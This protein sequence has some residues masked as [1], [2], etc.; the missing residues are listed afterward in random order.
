MFSEM[1]FLHVI[2]AGLAA[3]VVGFVWYLPPVLGK[4]WAGYVNGS[5]SGRF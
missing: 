5:V 3:L 2:L 4:R 1:D